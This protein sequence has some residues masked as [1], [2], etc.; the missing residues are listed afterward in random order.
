MGVASLVLGIISVLLGF[1]P[2]C[3]VIA[4]LPALIG[5]GLGITDFVV[6]SRSGQSKSIGMAGI[7]LNC[8][9][10]IVIILW[11]AVVSS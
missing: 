10:F 6:K 11:V 4:L 3:G 2:L 5:L 7:G 8:L 1:V 9:A